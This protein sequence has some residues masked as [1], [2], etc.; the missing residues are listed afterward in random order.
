VPSSLVS[1]SFSASFPPRS[2][3]LA[4]FWLGLDSCSWPVVQGFKEFGFFESFPPDDHA[5]LRTPADPPL[6]LA[7][8]APDSRL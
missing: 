3:L 1:A 4:R 5:G 7:L 2:A 6:S 8:L